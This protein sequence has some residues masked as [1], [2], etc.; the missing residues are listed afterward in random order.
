MKKKLASLFLALCMVVTLF[1]APALAADDD[2]TEAQPHLI[3]DLIELENFRDYINSGNTGAGEYFKLTADIDL[4]EKYNETTGV[5]WEMIG[6]VDY[7]GDTY[8]NPFQGTFDGGGHTISGL[9]I[10]KTGP[11]NEYG[12]D[13]GA[14]FGVVDGGTIQ[15]LNVQGYVSIAADN[16]EAAGIAGAVWDGA[17]LNCSFDG[18]VEC[19]NYIAAGITT[20]CNESVI[21]GCKANGRITGQHL[22]GGIVGTGDGT[23]IDC[24]NESEI[25]GTAPAGGIAGYWSGK[26]EN[27]VNRGSVTGRFYHPDWGGAWGD[28]SFDIGGIVGVAADSVIIENCCNLGAVSGNTGVG[29]IV[30]NS[31]YFI[32]EDDVE[33][34]TSVKNCL[35]VGTVTP[36]LETDGE[37]YIGSIIG[38]VTW[39]FFIDE[40]LLPGSADVSNCYYLAGTAEKGIAVCNDGTDTTTVKTANEFASGEV[41]YLLQEGNGGNTSAI[42]WG[43]TLAVDDKPVLTDEHENAV[44]KVAFVADETEYTVNYANPSGPVTKPAAPAK[45]GYTF[46]GWYKEA[47]CTNVWDFDTDTVTADVTLYA[48]WTKNSTGGTT[49]PPMPTP[50][51]TPKSDDRVVTVEQFTDV[52]S[53]TWYYEAVKYAV[54]NGLFYG[55]DEKTFTPHGNMTRGMLATVLYRLAKEPE[56]SANNL[57][58]DVADSTY[59]TEAITWAA[60]NK[61]VAGYGNH[62]FGPNDSI[63]REQLAAILWRY[64]GSPEYTGNLIRFTDGN[65]TS[66]WATPALCWAV[67]N[68]IVSGKDN[69]ILDPKGKATRA[70]VAAILMRYCEIL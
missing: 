51:P 65:K 32:D 20:G 15:N 23:I 66:N 60:E 63:T 24:I 59:Y 40:D 44:Y 6:V 69:G 56:T 70:E 13:E 8:E 39:D 53:D 30:G 1:P 54:D 47:D 19:P 2:G 17:I 46:G 43:Q 12:F 61:I 62:R 38:T 45:S 55:T 31:A 5:S 34:L 9:Y 48:K 4:S 58:S 67:E 10:N 42:V 25:I 21:S 64:A 22:V 57:F 36:T 52:K 26:I 14:L 68:K 18:V 11:G 28:S 49:T 35:N 50:A 7:W 27:C 37:H 33:Y 29:G 16:G 41:A 3:S